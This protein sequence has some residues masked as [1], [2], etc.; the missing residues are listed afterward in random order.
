MDFSILS[1][2]RGWI[3]LPIVALLLAMSSL[4]IHYQERV[5]ASSQWRGQLHDVDSELKIWQDFY[6]DLVTAPHFVSALASQCSVFCPLSEITTQKEWQSQNQ[7]LYYRWES[8]KLSAEEA[9]SPK[10]FYR[11]CATQNQQQYCCW[12]WRED[13]LLSNGWVSA[14]G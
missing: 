12:W 1:K 14:S 6:Q 9:D 5:L 11:L 2:F 7:F 13:R 3:S 10:S 8:Y 4:S